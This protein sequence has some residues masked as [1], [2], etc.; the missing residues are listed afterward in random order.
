MNGQ[1]IGFLSNI[2]D[3][4]A[5]FGRGF[6]PTIHSQILPLFKSSNRHYSSRYGQKFVTVTLFARVSFVHDFHSKA[7]WR[8]TETDQ[9]VIVYVKLFDVTGGR[10]HMPIFGNK[11]G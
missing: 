8:V 4:P 11:L 3:T 1:S 7:F 10:F 2:F 6:I 9:T 5:E